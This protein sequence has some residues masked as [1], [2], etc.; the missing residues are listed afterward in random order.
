[1]AEDEKASN[2]QLHVSTA[3]ESADKEVQYLE[4][5]RFYLFMTAYASISSYRAR[6]HNTVVS[7]WHFFSRILRYPSSQ[8]HLSPS[9]MTFMASK[10]DHGSYRDTS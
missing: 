10:A 5:P 2:G 8:P 1:M 3:E 4:G 6:A 9:P 7:Q